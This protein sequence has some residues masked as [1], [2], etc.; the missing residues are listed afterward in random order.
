MCE[1]CESPR[2]I[3][4]WAKCLIDDKLDLGVFPALYLSNAIDVIHN[5][6]SLIYFFAGDGN[7]FNVPINYCPMCGRKLLSVEEH[8]TI[9]ENIRRIRRERGLTLK[10]LGEAVGVSEA[11]IRAY[12]KGRRYPKY[13]SLVK[14]AKALDVSVDVFSGIMLAEANEKDRNNG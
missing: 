2:P 14:I 5:Q 4:D 7:E 6:L 3:D 10:Q 11:Y 8:M 12:E 1:Y 13:K 9:G